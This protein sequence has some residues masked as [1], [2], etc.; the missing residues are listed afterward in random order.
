MS[1]TKKT[2]SEDQIFS[3]LEMLEE[4]KS[5]AD[6]SDTLGVKKSCIYWHIKNRNMPIG[7]KVPSGRTRII[8]PEEVDYTLLPDSVLFDPKMFPS[9]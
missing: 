8:L 3:I 4:G 5:V 6:I 7:K 9:F 1:E 2:L